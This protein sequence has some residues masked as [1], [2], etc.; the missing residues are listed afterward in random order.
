MV[1]KAK[2]RTIVMRLISSA[3]TGFFYTTTR[4]RALPKLQLMKYDPLVN[5]HVL[6][7]EGKK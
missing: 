2:A 5:K 6:F 3:G 7:V 4:R 1:K